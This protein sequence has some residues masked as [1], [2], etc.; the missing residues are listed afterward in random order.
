MHDR[1]ANGQKLKMLTVVD[2]WTRACVAI[3]VDDRIP[4]AR[5][6]NVIQALMHQ[7]GAPCFL[8]SDNGPEF[9]AKALKTWL[10]RR[11]VQTAYIDA[12]KPWQN[13]T[14][15]SFNGKIRDECLNLEWFR[16]R[17]EARIVIAPWR[18]QYNEQRPH[19]SLGYQT[20]AQVRQQVGECSPLSP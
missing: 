9:I 18:Q 19:S 13:G 1:C 16:H 20:P 7:Y 3:E 11:G 14:N 8:R 15:E 4:A 12:G 2:E 6:I 5:V 17:L 10:Q